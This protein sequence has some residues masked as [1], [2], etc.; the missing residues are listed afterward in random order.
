METHSSILAWRIV[1]TEKPGGLQFMGSQRVW[2]N[3]SDLACMHALEKE[4][5]THSTILAWRIREG[6]AWWA[7][8]YGATQS[9]TQLKWL[10]SSSSSNT[11]FPAPFIEETLWS[12]VY[13]CLLFHALIDHKRVCIYSWALYSVFLMDMSG[14]VLVKYCFDYGSLQV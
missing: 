1:W 13:S 12:I 5:A 14:F 11:V 2:H 10:S 9:R 8:V 3:W 6:G 4:M 7:A